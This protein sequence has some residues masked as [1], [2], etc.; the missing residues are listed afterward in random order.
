METIVG[1]AFVTVT[2]VDREELPPSSSLA[3]AVTV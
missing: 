2:V 3:V 1:A